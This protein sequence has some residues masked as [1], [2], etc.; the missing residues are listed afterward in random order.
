[1]LKM[2]E[3]AI[4]LR[5]KIAILTRESAKKIKMAVPMRDGDFENQ[6]TVS[7]CGTN[8]LKTKWDF[9]EAGGQFENENIVLTIK[10]STIMTKFTEK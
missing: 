10:I 7:R 5:L 9:P 1:M 4:N 2:K 6:N 8:G 3:K